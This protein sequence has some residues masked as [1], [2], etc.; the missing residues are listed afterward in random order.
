MSSAQERYDVLID[1]I[2]A[3]PTPTIGLPNNEWIELKNVSNSPVNL[4]NWRIG[5]A[6]TI[7]GP[8]PNYT[9]QPDS[10]LIVCGN[11]SLPALSSFGAC[12]AVSSFPSLDNDGDLIYIK[13]ASGKSIHAVN[14]STSWYNN[15]LKKDGGWTLEMTDTH[16]GCT[17]KNNWKAS[18]DTRGGSPGKKNSTDGFISNTDLPKLQRAY[19]ID[20]S[21][22]IVVYTGT[23][24]S[25]ASATKANY[26]IDGGLAFNYAASIA[27]AFNEVLLK[28]STPLQAG[29]IY[30]LTA[31]NI[32]DC[33]NN[34]VNTDKVIKIGLP[35]DPATGEW[36]INEILFN[37]RPNAFDY[38]ELYNNG[39][40]ILDASKMFIANRNSSGA[41]A[42]IKTLSNFPFY[43]FPGEYIVVTENA[44]NLALQYLVEDPEQVLTITSLPSFPD[45]EGVVLALNSQGMVTD[46]LKY[47]DD[48]HFKLLADP[49]GVSLERIDPATL[50]QQESNWHSAASTSGFGTPGYKNSQ[51]KLLGTINASIEITPKIFSPDNDGRD[52]LA[53]IQYVVTEPG[54]IANIIIY[55]PSGRPVRRLTGGAVMGLN[56]HWNWDGLDDKRNKLPAGVYIACTEIFNLEGE[57][58]LFKNTVVLARYLD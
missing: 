48:W 26:E 45:D 36:I 50:T 29:T 44:E 41:P 8:F 46:E 57:K 56:G 32:K 21:T 2:M 10:F 1:E 55:D 7:S 4:Q 53:T 43:I 47:R 33:K 38:V 58:Q 35:A 27:P 34:L 23:I 11:S 22:I 5:D 51:F 14:Y 52:D 12:I 54:F 18:T 30:H 31:R 28:T 40:K 25:L 19:T 15:E 49:E 13:A 39:K 17:G 16:M 20:S 9:L 6:T 42:S 3:D 24:D 37:P